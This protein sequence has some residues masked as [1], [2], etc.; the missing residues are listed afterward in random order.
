M[1]QQSYKNY[2]Y[3]R[4][5]F[6]SDEKS[7]LRVFNHDYTI[8]VCRLRCAKFFDK[9]LFRNV[10]LLAS[11]C[12]IFFST[13]LNAAYQIKKFTLNNGGSSLSSSR[14]SLSASVHRS[15]LIVQFQARDFN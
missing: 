3:Q 9:E 7:V 4:E 2:F 11:F 8:L 6:V 13:Q 15:I 5:R 14:F 1:P 12:F 10:L